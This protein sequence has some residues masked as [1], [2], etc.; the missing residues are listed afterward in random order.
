MAASTVPDLDTRLIH[1]L[2][3]MATNEVSIEVRCDAIRALAALPQLALV[4]SV[5]ECV[6]MAV[7][8]LESESADDVV[9]EVAR[10]CGAHRLAQRKD[11]FAA[12]VKRTKEADSSIVRSEAAKAITAAGRELPEDSESAKRLLLIK[13]AL[14]NVCTHENTLRAIRRQT[15]T[16]SARVF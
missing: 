9:V 12:L 16:K 7:R 13:S 10:F 14:K 1:Q 3:L 5:E 11:T 15:N 2:T 4:E 6:G 8:V